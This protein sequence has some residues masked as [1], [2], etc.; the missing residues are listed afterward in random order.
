M[1]DDMTPER[2]RAL[3]AALPARLHA[4]EGGASGMESEWQPEPYEER[5]HTV[6]DRPD[7]EGWC[8]DSG[9][10]GYCL[11]RRVAEALAAAPDLARAYLAAEERAERLR[12]AL[13]DSEAMRDLW[14][15]QLGDA[16]RERDAAEERAR[17]A[18]ARLAAL[19]GGGQ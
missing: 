1:G 6:S 9:H 11:P 5:T 18:E 8:T 16:R 14:S 7:R 2:A 19:D 3:L 10:R 12:L 4:V 17:A 13:G 15:R